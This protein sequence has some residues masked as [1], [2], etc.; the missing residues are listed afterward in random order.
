[1]HTC[2][3]L[4]M[5][6][7]GAALMLPHAR[8]RPILPIHVA[9]VVRGYLGNKH[10]L[11]YETASSLGVVAWLGGTAVCET[12]ARPP[13]CPLATLVDCMSL[14]QSGTAHELQHS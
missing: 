7:V 2:M 12:N 6:H 3:S 9:C 5:H 11:I 13:A 1:M 8:A 14:R 4:G 10:R